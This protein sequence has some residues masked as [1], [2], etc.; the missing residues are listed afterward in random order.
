MR[1]DTLVRRVRK[2]ACESDHS[3]AANVSRRRNA[4]NLYSAANSAGCDHERSAEDGS[5]SHVRGAPATARIRST[6]EHARWR[7]VRTDAECQQMSRLETLPRF[8]RLKV[9]LHEK[10]VDEAESEDARKERSKR[11]ARGTCH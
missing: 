11:S 4:S 2:H 8:I 3:P 7:G 5:H 10:G 1:G 9:R 6:P